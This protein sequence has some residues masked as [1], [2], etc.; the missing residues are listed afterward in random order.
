MTTL[1]QIKY[2]LFTMSE[3]QLHDILILIEEYLAEE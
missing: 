1:D 2:Y 3:E